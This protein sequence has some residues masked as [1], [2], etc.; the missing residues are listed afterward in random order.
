MDPYPVRKRF[1]LPNARVMI[2]QPHGATQ[3]QSVDLEI[4]AKE[5]LHLRRRTEEVLARHTGQPIER[6]RQDTDRDR[7]FGPEEAVTY[8]LADEVIARRPLPS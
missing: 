1:V 5:I 8:G 7:F 6:I 2:H 4:H 3:G